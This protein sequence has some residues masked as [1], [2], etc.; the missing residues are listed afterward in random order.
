MKKNLLLIILLTLAQQNFTQYF[1]PNS[2]VWHYNYDPSPPIEM[3]YTKIVV[4]G[5]TLLQGKACK[6]LQKRNIG[7]DFM[8][9]T[10]YD[11]PDGCQYIYSDPDKVYYYKSN[12]FYTLYDFAAK[13][14]SSW[15]ITGDPDF[16]NDSLAKIEVDSINNITINSIKLR[17]LYIHTDSG[18]YAFP[19]NKIIEKI[20]SVDYMF[21]VRTNLTGPSLP[22]PLRCYFDNAFGLFQNTLSS[23]DSIYT[24]VGLLANSN[25]TIKVYPNPVESIST[26]DWT[27]TG[28]DDYNISIYNF[29]GQLVSTQPAHLPSIKI[30]KSDFKPG[31][32]FYILNTKN[33]Q[34]GNGKFE[35]N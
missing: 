10:N 2:S 30:Y 9:K 11:Y 4:I 29:S 26:I 14:G 23:C 32:Y 25:F 6:I 12:K 21:P 3:G 22:G 31:I 20:G 5:D 28:E 24:N 8:K 13:K 17:V 27:S 1:A 19:G 18:Y 16:T 7:Y 35:I 15:I 34:L 33:R